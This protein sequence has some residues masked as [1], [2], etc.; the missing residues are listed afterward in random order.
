MDIPVKKKEINIYIYYF[1]E[2]S[3]IMKKV[4]CESTVEKCLHAASDELNIPIEEMKYTVLEEKKS[5]FKK[6]AKIEVEFF[7]EKSN[8]KEFKNLEDVEIKENCDLDNENDGTI[9]IIDGKIIITNPEEGGK[10]AAILV[11]NDIKVLVDGLEIKGKKE[12]FKENEIEVIFNEINGSRELKIDLSESYM[13]AYATINYKPKYEYK[14]KDRKKNGTA[15]LEA[16]IES[17]INPPKYT[18]EEVKKE[19]SSNKVIYGII[20][21]N[22]KQCV[23]NGGVKL[24]VAKGQK[25]VDGKN[26]TIELKFK[27]DKGSEKLK[28]DEVGNIDFKSIGSVEAVH[29]SDVIAVRQLGDEGQDGCDVTG[30]VKKHKLG[31]SIKLKVGEGCILANENTIVAAIDGKPCIKSNAFFVYQLHEVRSDV[32]LKTGNIKFIGDVIVYGNVKEG[33]EVECGNN[34]NIEKDVERAK[35][36]AGGNINLKG[37]LIAGTVFAGGEDVKKLKALKDLADLKDQVS[38]LIEAVGEIKKFHLL[39]KDRKDGEVV[40]ILI[41]NKYKILPKLCLSVVT[42]LKLQDDNSNI[43]IY[44]KLMDLIRSKLLGI[45]PI[46][47]QNYSELDLIVSSIEEIIFTLKNTLSIPVDIRISYCQDS[48]I[49][50]SGDV[51]ITGKGEY[52]SD[53]TANGS[54][55]FLQEKS[56]ARGGI[57]RAKEEIKC[58]TVGSTAGVATKLQVEKQGHIWVDTAYQNTIFLVGNR[59]FVLEMPSRNVHAYVD[60]NDDIIVDKLKL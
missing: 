39:G 33:M 53:I 15:I 17:Q 23:E 25:V 9:E 34:L 10:P 43:E 46:S 22:L 40:K 12:V 28:E 50:G 38:S 45:A 56:V 13:E 11:G 27:T 2:G 57:L 55:Y 35:I 47:I 41:E 18:V 54:I 49:K 3:L 5:F 59:E 60:S 30:R 31:K 58:R 48:N 6:K 1:I 21:E 29:K 4:Y 52:I 16:E 8:G 44:N 19:L 14:L 7:D 36:K 37:N 24:L 51:F 20:E 42:D 26:D 32:D